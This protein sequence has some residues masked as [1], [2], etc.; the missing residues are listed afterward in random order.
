MYAGMAG[1]PVSSEENIEGRRTLQNS[2]SRTHRILNND[3]LQNGKQARWLE[4]EV[5]GKVFFDID[6]VWITYLFNLGKVRNLNGFYDIR[7][8]TALFASHNL[9]H[10]ISPR[11]AQ[12]T[13]LTLLD[14]SYNQ[15]TLIPTEIGDMGSL[16]H[17]NISNNQLKTLPAEMGKLFR[18]KALSE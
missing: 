2:A 17:L 15:I 9:V 14:L 12:L 1:L 10:S 11:I 16:T 13:S 5:H 3:E 4:L 6:V 7:H 18:L 8:L